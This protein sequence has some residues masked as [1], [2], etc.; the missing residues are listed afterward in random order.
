MKALRAR[1][2]VFSFF[3][4]SIS[5]LIFWL[6]HMGIEC[7]ECDMD[8]SN[9][10]NNLYYLPI[11]TIVLFNVGNLLVVLLAMISYKNENAGHLIPYMVYINLT[12]LLAQDSRIQ[13]FMILLLAVLVF[14]ATYCD[15]AFNLAFFSTCLGI[16]HLLQTYFE[17][18]NAKETIPNTLVVLI[19]NI[20]LS[21]C[22]HI[23]YMSIGEYIVTIK[24]DSA[25]FKVL[26]NKVD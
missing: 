24:M 7:K 25:R 1:S 8:E 19:C 22:M 11:R 10:W 3:Y 12:L 2:A 18:K 15:L 16:L 17:F 4:S 14:Q 26:L 6:S 20:F 21:C 9:S 23:S 13:D 5:I